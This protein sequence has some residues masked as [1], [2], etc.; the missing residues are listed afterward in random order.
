MFRYLSL[1]INNFDHKNKE[2]RGEHRGKTFGPRLYIR[3]SYR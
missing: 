1:N 3:K 2:N